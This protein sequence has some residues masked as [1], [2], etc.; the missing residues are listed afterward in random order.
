MPHDPLPALVPAERD[1]ADYHAAAE[2]GPSPVVRA[3]IGML[4]GVVAGL[5]AALFVP[6]RRR[7]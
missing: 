3:A 5:V 1:L 6:R 2:P 4:L 7:H